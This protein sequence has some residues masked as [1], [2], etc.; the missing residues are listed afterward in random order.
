MVKV[1]N[2]S[3][4]SLNKYPIY[5]NKY[6][7]KFFAGGPPPVFD[8]VEAMMADKLINM[9]L[10]DGENISIPP[11]GFN[12]PAMES[13]LWGKP[14][15]AVWVNGAFA[16]GSWA[17]YKDGFENNFRA[18]DPPDHLRMFVL[19]NMSENLDDGQ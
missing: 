13:W 14:S 7:N 11:D 3:G 12:K 1:T 8:Q 10:V 2:T 6:T 5:F 9:Y 16:D 19:L 17:V 4:G 18:S 15:R